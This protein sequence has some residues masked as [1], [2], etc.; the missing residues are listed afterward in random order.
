[1]S[2]HGWAVEDST[3]LAEARVQV[4]NRRPDVVLVTL[5]FGADDVLSFLGDLKD[6]GIDTFVISESLRV[7]DRIAANLL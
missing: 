7:Q 6:N 1:M 5:E 2:Q 3:N 4:D